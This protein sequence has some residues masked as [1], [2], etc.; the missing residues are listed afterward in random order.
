MQDLNKL[1]L[2]EAALWQGDDTPEG[3]RWI[4]GG[5][6]RDNVITYLRRA[7]ARQ[8]EVTLPDGA[9]GRLLLPSGKEISFTRRVCCED[10]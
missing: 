6:S 7:G 9:E 8:Y 1:Y 5:N 4:D 3:F 10:A 2:R